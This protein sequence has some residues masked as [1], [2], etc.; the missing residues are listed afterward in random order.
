MENQTLSV[1]VTLYLLYCRFKKEI[2]FVH[3]ACVSI[4]DDLQLSNA[5]H[6][7]SNEIWTWRWLCRAVD[8]GIYKT[9][10]TL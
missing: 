1:V 6:L 10:H 5:V 3:Y 9:Q 8:F 2:E 7:F 4:I